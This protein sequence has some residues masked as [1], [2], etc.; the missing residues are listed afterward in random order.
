MNHRHIELKFFIVNNLKQPSFR[1]D[2]KTNC[3]DASD[4][5]GWFLLLVLYI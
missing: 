2:G 4:E 1:C 3:E 5:Q